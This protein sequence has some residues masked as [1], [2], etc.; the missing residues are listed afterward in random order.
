MSDPPD[1]SPIADEVGAK[2]AQ[3][4]AA[5]EATAA[6]IVSAA[7]DEADRIV[8]RAQR[9]AGEQL[10]RAEHAARELA[11]EAGRLKQS[12]SGESEVAAVA[13]AE[14]GAAISEK[15]QEDGPADDA[16]A[17]LVAMNMA[18]DGASS[19]E[20]AR[21]LTA[22]FPGIDGTDELVAEVLAKAGR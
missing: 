21:R 12:I 3:I 13:G 9:D 10:E 22:D 5:A 6:E 20:I 8:E 15:G 14:P 19:N 4:V 18:L 17:R 11:A 1:S 16:G 2:V 7:R